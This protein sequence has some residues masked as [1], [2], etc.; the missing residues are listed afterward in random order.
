[1]PSLPPRVLQ[2]F[3]AHSLVERVLGCYSP[4][5]RE[6]QGISV[7]SLWARLTPEEQ[8]QT[9]DALMP[10]VTQAAQQVG[11]ILQVFGRIFRAGVLPMGRRAA[12]SNTLFLAPNGMGDH[13]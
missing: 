9:T 7:V 12:M 5:Y 8:E 3:A 2:L 4:N 11:E 6:G 10:T 13:R 1:M